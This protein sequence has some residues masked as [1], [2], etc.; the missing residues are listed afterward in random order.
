MP[1]RFFRF[2]PMLAVVLLPG[3]G[4]ASEEFVTAKGKTVALP[5]ITTMTCGQMEMT[6]A[7]IDATRYRENA[8][9]NADPADDTLFAYEQ[10]LARALFDI[11][12]MGT[13]RAP[14]QG[15]A[16]M[17]PEPVSN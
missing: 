1:L 14:G 6:L 7:R 11:C 16:A 3:M 9:V 13:R 2:M 17:R 12:V 4:V 5:D 15:N 8:P 10:N